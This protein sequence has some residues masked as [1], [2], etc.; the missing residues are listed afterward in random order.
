HKLPQTLCLHAE[1]TFLPL[2]AFWCGFDTASQVHRLL[3]PGAPAAQRRESRLTPPD[4]GGKPAAAANIRS[5]GRPGGAVMR[6]SRR[7]AVAAA[8]ALTLWLRSHF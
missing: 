5:S 4:V 8:T 6:R 7:I 3:S 1:G 2:E